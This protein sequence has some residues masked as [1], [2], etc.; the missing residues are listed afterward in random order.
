M[1]AVADYE[2]GPGAVIPAEEAASAIEM[3]TRFV[4]VIA[5]LLA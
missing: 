1:K 2:L 4:S 3:A 5:K